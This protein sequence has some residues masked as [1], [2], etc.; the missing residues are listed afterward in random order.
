MLRTPGGRKAAGRP[1]CTGSKRAD[2]SGVR[3]PLAVHPL[4]GSIRGRWQGGANGMRPFASR[5]AFRGIA[6]RAPAAP[7]RTSSRGDDAPLSSRA[8]GLESARISSAARSADAGR[9]AR[10]AS[11]HSALGG[12]LMASRPG[13]PQRRAGGPSGD[14]GARWTASARSPGG[15]SPARLDP[16]ALVG[17]R[18]ERQTIRHT[19]V[20]RSGPPPGA[21]GGGQGSA[22][23]GPV[24]SPFSGTRTVGAAGGTPDVAPRT[25]VAVDGWA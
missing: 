3:P 16:R 5:K 9:G 17:G 18:E 1:H 15:A 13:R 20:A 12:S 11:S 25:R 10:G 14:D 2:P 24:R 23:S 6:S 8:R 19:A 7:R 21:P 4:R 22:A